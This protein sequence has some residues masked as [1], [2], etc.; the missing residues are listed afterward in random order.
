M[1]EK[2]YQFFVKDIVVV[3]VF[4]PSRKENEMKDLYDYDWWLV[5]VVCVI[6]GLIFT[7]VMY[8]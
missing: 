6:F 2:V 7:C 4:A 3:E 8:N 5:L 1:Y